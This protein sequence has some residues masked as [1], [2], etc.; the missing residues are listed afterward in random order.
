MTT[1]QWMF[2]DT[3]PVYDSAVPTFADSI[4]ANNLTLIPDS[5]PATSSIP[6]R[7]GAN[8]VG[9][10][11]CN[12][13]LFGWGKWDRILTDVEIRALLGGEQWPFSTT[14]SLQ[15]CVAYFPLNGGNPFDD[16]TGR[17]NDLSATGSP[18]ATTNQFGTGATALNGA[19]LG[20]SITADLQTGNYDVTVF[21]W[22]RLNSKTSP[23]NPPNQQIFWGQCDINSSP[24]KTGMVV[25]YEGS[26]D[27]FNIDLGN[28]VDLYGNGVVVNAGMPTVGAWTT[29]LSQYESS[30]GLM[31]GK[32]I[33]FAEGSFSRVVNPSNGSELHFVSAAQ[34]GGNPPASGWDNAPVIR[35]AIATPGSDVQFGNRDRSVT[36]RFKADVPSTTTAQ[37]LAGI[38]DKN[39]T[40][41]DWIVQMNSNTIYF[42]IGNGA[43][44]FEYAS[45]PFSD[46]SSDHVL[47][48]RLDATNGVLYMDL[49]GGAI[50][51]SHTLTSITPGTCPVPFLVGACTYT[52]SGDGA[53]E[54][55][56]GTIYDLA[57]SAP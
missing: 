17:G 22:V 35:V 40:L 26:H 12:A 43:G 4:N 29:L 20:R 50:T 49:D 55:F 13:D 45:V 30:T 19:Y 47:V 8:S 48:C 27:S 23:S 41:I 52:G 2:N 54:Q 56:Q 24:A 36:I 33:T 1:A 15:D 3:L 28:G 34:F 6:F 25:Y 21:G 9:N 37:T 57:L 51:A 5:R 44:S 14:T 7:I 46:T 11:T 32:A 18:M 10:Q 42:V 53:D 39:G 38:Y 16:A 31:S